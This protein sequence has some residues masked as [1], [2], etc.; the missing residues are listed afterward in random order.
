MRVH[1]RAQ[2]PAAVEELAGG[3]WAPEDLLPLNGSAA[4][5]AALRER[6]LLARAAAK[7]R[8]DKR[9][10][11]G[12]GAGAEE[13]VAGAVTAP[14]AA[15]APAS[16]PAAAHPGAPGDAPWMMLRASV[17]LCHQHV[18]V[19]VHGSQGRLVPGSRWCRVSLAGK[20]VDRAHDRHRVAL[21]RRLA[22]R[23]RAR[24]ARCAR[25]ARRRGAGA[26][27]RQEV[28]GAWHTPSWNVLT[29]AWCP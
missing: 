9:R 4:E 21:W 23:R 5:V 3:R 6:M 2:V 27:A 13:P 15:P 8:K 18:F 25:R 14:V 29:C 11:G 19:L 7:R 16:S 26:G 10:A 1:A 22:G 17:I 28:Q 12:V 24:W 20:L